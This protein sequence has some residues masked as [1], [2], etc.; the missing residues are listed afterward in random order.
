MLT[1]G[2]WESRAERCD[3]I[4]DVEV[5]EGGRLVKKKVGWAATRERR[6]ARGASPFPAFRTALLEVGRVSPRI[7]L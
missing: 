1:T 7:T 4:M 6:L 2:T 5:V 3:V